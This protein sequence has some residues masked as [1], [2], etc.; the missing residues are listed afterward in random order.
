[1]TEL[2]DQAPPPLTGRPPDKTDRNSH[3]KEDSLTI[4]K[5]EGQDFDGTLDVKCH[6]DGP[7]RVVSSRLYEGDT[8]LGIDCRHYFPTFEEAAKYIA[9]TRGLNDSADPV[10]VS[11]EGIAIV[12]DE[13][14]IYVPDT[15]EQFRDKYHKRLKKVYYHFGTD[16]S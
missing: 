1:M 12:E 2:K 3:L 5:W 4:S 16:I 7:W 14:A 13:D 9:I 10:T 11:Y 15:W 8:H 6:G